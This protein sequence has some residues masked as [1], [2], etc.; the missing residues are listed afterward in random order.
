MSMNQ[1]PNRVGKFTS[2]EIHRL[3]PDKRGGGNGKMDAYI[4]EKLMEIV[5][6]RGADKDSN[7]RPLTWGKICERLVFQDP[8]IISLEYAREGAIQIVHPT[9]PWSGSRDGLKSRE[10]VFD[11]KCPY[12]VKSWFDF[13]RC[14]TIEDVIANHKDGEK[15]FWQLVSNAILSG[16][17]KAQLVVFMPYQSQL[18]AIRELAQG[19]AD[20]DYFWITYAKD[21]DMPYLTDGCGLSNVKHIEFDVTP[22][23]IA[24]LTSRVEIA[25][26]ALKAE[27]EKFKNEQGAKASINTP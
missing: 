10:T 13:Y 1:N 14:N 22:D 15:Y 26:I 11:L 2:S 6:G 4:Q 7:A 27:V 9:L 20:G 18:D 21:E 19:T 16:V 5:L 23:M 8:D 17:T 24:A 25:S 3:M 12:T